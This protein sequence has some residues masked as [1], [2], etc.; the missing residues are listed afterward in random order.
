MNYCHATSSTQCIAYLHFN[1]R[2]CE[3]LTKNQRD[4]HEASHQVARLPRLFSQ[5][6]YIHRTEEK[7]HAHYQIL[8]KLI[9]TMRAAILAHEIAQ[10]QLSHG[11]F[12]ASYITRHLQDALFEV[13]QHSNQLLNLFIRAR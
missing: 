13:S 9:Y 10:L 7:P 2:S 4:A 8:A 12:D 6:G 3:V 1:Q 5:A 11:F